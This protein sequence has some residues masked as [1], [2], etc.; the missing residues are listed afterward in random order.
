MNK[1]ICQAYASLHLYCHNHMNY[2]TF[3]VSLLEKR[4]ISDS[5]FC[6]YSVDKGHFRRNLVGRKNAM[7]NYC[8]AFLMDYW[9]NVSSGIYWR[10]LL[11][12][13]L[14]VLSHR[15]QENHLTKFD[16]MSVTKLIKLFFFFLN[17]SFFCLK[18]RKKPLH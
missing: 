4:V 12:L 6:W 1:K 18:C 15:Y 3:K 13:G 2:N 11:R 9:Q 7:G 16:R 8:D 5:L 17:Y 14:T 10:N